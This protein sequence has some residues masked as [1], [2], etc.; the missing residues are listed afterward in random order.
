VMYLSV[1]SAAACAVCTNVVFDDTREHVLSCCCMSP[2]T[3]LS[4]TQL[5]LWWSQH[6]KNIIV[7]VFADETHRVIYRLSLTCVASPVQT[8]MLPRIAGSI[9]RNVRL[10]PRYVSYQTHIPGSFL[11]RQV[12]RVLQGR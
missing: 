5:R 6:S 12:L 1:S 7:V 3:T 11:L 9:V 10:M 2:N 4:S 8:T